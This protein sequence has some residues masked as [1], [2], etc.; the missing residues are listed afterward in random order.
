MWMLDEDLPKI[1]IYHGRQDSAVPYNGTEK[2]EETL[3]GLE[4][5]KEK[6][7]I[8]IQEGEHGFDSLDEL[9]LDTPWLNED[10][11]FVTSMWLA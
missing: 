4:G 8:S 11:E 1:S 3:K 2:S 6:I 10:P 7:S 9:T 5:G